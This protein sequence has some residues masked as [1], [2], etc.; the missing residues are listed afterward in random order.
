MNAVSVESAIQ[1]HHVYKSIR[2][3]VLGEVLVCKRERHNIHDPFAVVVYKGSVIVGHVSWHISAMY[4]T[5]LGNSR[6]SITCKVTD[7]SRCIR[8]SPKGGLEVPCHLIFHRE[9]NIEKIRNLISLL[10]ASQ[11]IEKI[12]IVDGYS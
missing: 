3:P 5:F 1:G 2:A 11:L 7:H 12:K 9:V 6:C 4:H 8:D 10:N